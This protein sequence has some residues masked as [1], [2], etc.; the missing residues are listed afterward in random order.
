[1]FEEIKLQASKNNGDINNMNTESGLDNKSHV[2]NKTDL[3]NDSNLHH[4]GHH[5]SRH[6]KNRS[7]KDQSSLSKFIAK[8]GKQNIK[9]AIGLIL[10]ISAITLI[11]WQMYLIETQKIII[12]SPQEGQNNDAYNYGESSKEDSNKTSHY[13]NSITVSVPSYWEKMIEEKTKTVKAIQTAGGINSVSFAWVS[14]T[15]IPDNS[16]AKTDDLGKIMSEIMDNCDIPFAVLTGDIGTRASYETEAELVKTQSMIPIHLAPLWGTDRLLMALGNHDG[17][18]GDSSCYYAKQFSPERMWQLY[19]RNQAL[20]TRRVFSNDGLYYY[21]DNKAQKTRFIV[22]NSNFSGEYVADGD[23]IAQNNRFSTSC[24]GQEQLDWLANV[25]LDM[26]NGYDAIIFSHVPPNITYTVDKIQLI[27]IINA[28][29]RKSVYSGSYNVGVDGWTNN[30]VNVDFTDAEG[31]IIAMFSGHV[32]QDTVDTT[33]LDCPLITIISAG[34]P[35]NEGESPER[36]FGTDTETSFDVVT[37]NKKTRTIY[38]TRIGA[39][40][41]RIIKY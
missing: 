5:S 36:T 7:S 11:M 38:C 18:Y 22:L 32:H 15:H 20:D 39:G 33:T 41:D 35:V 26:P 19:F 1:M 30:K 25:A 8:V 23:C 31:E 27:G 37:I 34:A 3:R 29:C 14:D 4:H 17:C 6:K 9:K 40:E 10:V 2:I 28:F 13:S 21:V 12:K 16:S 24:Y